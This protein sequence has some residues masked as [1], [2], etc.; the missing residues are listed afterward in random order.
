M[1]CIRISVS[2]RLSLHNSKTQKRKLR[3]HNLNTF[4]CYNNNV[5]RRSDPNFNLLNLAF[6]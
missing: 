4:F 5:L 1:D 2:F 6:K 3:C